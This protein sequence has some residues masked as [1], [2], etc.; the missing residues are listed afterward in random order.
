MSQLHRSLH[1]G[2]RGF[3]RS[4]ALAVGTVPLA[5]LI[6]ACSQPA[7]TPA[8]TKP[9]ERPAAAPTSA[10]PAA[11]PAA[12]GAAPTPAAAATP[13][14]AG[15]AT[16]PAAAAAGTPADVVVSG[17]A[18]KTIESAVLK[19]PEPNP[20]KGGEARIAIGVTTSHFDV[21]QGG[22][23]N[24][25]CQAYNT[26]VRWNLGD[27]LR[28]IIPDLAEKWDIAPDG[29]TYTFKLR[30]GVKFH[31]G[32]PFTA[33]DVVASF[34]RIIFP[35]SGITSPNKALF[36]VVDGVE[37][38]DDMT[39]RFSLKE[40]RA[41][42]L[43]LLADPS[44]VIYSKKTLDANGGDLKKVQIA[45]GTGPYTLK[46]YRQAER[47][48]FERNP[49][50]WEP[51]LPYLDRQVWLHVP[52][53]TDRGTAVLTNQADMSWNVSQETWDEGKKRA[54][55]IAVNQLRNFGAYAVIF[56]TKKKPLDDPRVRRAIHLAVSRADLIKA[57]QTQEAIAPKTRWI[58]HG[59]PFA[60][61]PDKIAQIAGYR[62]DKKD[63]IQAAKKLL[64]DAG[65]PN[66]FGPV[67]FLSAN[68]PPHAEIMAPAFQEQLKRTLNIETKIRTQERALLGQ[69]QQDGKFEIV[70]DTPGHLLSDMSPIGST[71]WKT[72]GSRNYGGYSNKDFDKLLTQYDSSTDEAKRREMAD[73]MQDILDQDP[74]W[75]LIG[76][77]FHLPMWQK[78]FKGMVLDNR[79]FAQWGPVTTAWMDK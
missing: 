22:N 46:E 73:Q 48:I 59:D 37:K 4:L 17:A 74:P 70:V 13:A 58:P 20:K 60:T 53:W 72:G 10:P 55:Q 52:A 71:Y 75:Y 76:F 44:M 25:M 79:A 31:D 40:P 78:A 77:T 11:T 35:E 34:K 7:P 68:V 8:P 69:E 57:F 9:A 3:L 6:A 29:K 63:D 56:N 27:G 16:K 30:N 2:R 65:Y 36:A 28:T 23:S 33:D 1:L 39:V 54:D 61:P 14:A 32:T 42:M 51:G 62:D 67:E 26:L 66:G 47:W 49:N 64:A 5:P 45:P 50:Y 24:V 12:A 19:A 38:T 43:K 15:A 18:P 41:Y 21:H